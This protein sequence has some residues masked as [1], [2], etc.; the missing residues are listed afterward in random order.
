MKASFENIEAKK[1]N[2]SFL[3]YHLRVPAFPFKWHYHPEY[4]LTLITRGEGKRLVGDNYE[5]FTAGDLVL[6]GTGLPHTWMSAPECTE[7]VSAIVIQFSKKFIESFFTHAEFMAIASLLGHSS[8][9]LHF[10]G[11]GKEVLEEI[12]QLPAQAPVQKI[13]SLLH[14]LQCLTSVAGRPLASPYFLP[15][16]GEA[17]ENRLNKVFEYIH[18][19]FQD[20]LSLTQAASL[21]HLSESAFCKFF[22]R[23]TGKTFSAYVNEIRI[24]RAATLLI[25]SDK[26]IGQIASEAGFESLTYFNRVFFQAKKTSPREFR[27]SF[28]RNRLQKKPER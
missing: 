9:G 2:A 20:G 21:I 14:I 5:D 7:E 12:V 17:N 3:V 16:K 26:S 6:L 15:V 10:T 1:A 23:A 27:K 22:K 24:G 18:T 4:E 19:H 28:L 11:A 8:G 13:L 25:E